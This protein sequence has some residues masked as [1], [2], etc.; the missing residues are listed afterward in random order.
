MDPFEFIEV[1]TVENG[2][3]LTYGAITPGRSELIT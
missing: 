1:F 2:S 3:T